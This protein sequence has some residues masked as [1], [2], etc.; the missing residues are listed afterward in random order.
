MS[1]NTDMLEAVYNLE[2]IIKQLEEIEARVKI[3]REEAV[4]LLEQVSGPN[5]AIDGRLASQIPIEDLN[6]SSRAY[7]ALK[8]SVSRDFNTVNDL[9]NTTEVEFYRIHNFGKASFEEVKRKLEELGFQ[10]PVNKR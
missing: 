5:I 10:L 1:I 2:M 4:E 9:L 7:N 6:L 8:R 3:M